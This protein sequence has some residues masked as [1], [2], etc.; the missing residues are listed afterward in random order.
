M[1]AVTQPALAIGWPEFGIFMLANAIIF[2]ICFPKL[3]QDIV[4]WRKGG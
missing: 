3:W 2:W 1:I 4:R